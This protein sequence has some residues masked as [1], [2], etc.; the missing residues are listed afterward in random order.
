GR[1]AVLRSVGRSSG[2]SA[3]EADAE[4]RVADVLSSLG[5]LAGLIGVRLGYIEADAIAALVV[6][7]LIARAAVR[8]SWRAGDILMDRAPTGERTLVVEAQ[9]E[10]ANL[11]ERVHAAAERMGGFH[12]LHNVTVEKEED[13]SLH[14][15]MHAKLPGGTTLAE[16]SRSSGQLEDELR[17]E[18]PEVSRVD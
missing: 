6:A 4:N 10:A 17:A 18:L 7:A 16:A 12:D 1:A 13:G 8:V 15:T 14:L 2:S 3:L 5:V 9:A 11:V